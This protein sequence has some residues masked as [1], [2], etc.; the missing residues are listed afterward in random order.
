MFDLRRVVVR[1]LLRVRRCFVMALRVRIGVVPVPVVACRV[2]FIVLSWKVVRIFLRSL[3]LLCR[4]RLRIVLILRLFLLRFPLGMRVLLVHR[5]SIPIEGTACRRTVCRVCLVGKRFGALLRVGVLG[6][7]S[8]S[9]IVR[10]RRVLRVGIRF[11]VRELVRVVRVGILAIKVV[12]ALVDGVPRASSVPVRFSLLLLL[13]VRI[14]VLLPVLFPL[15]LLLLLHLSLCSLVPSI[16]LGRLIALEGRLPVWIRH[17]RVGRGVVDIARIVRRFPLFLTWGS[18]LRGL[19]LVVAV[20][21]VPRLVLRVGVIVVSLSLR[22][23]R[24]LLLVTVVS[25]LP[26]LI[27]SPEFGTR[28]GFILL[29]DRVHV[30]LRLGVILTLL[31]IVERGWILIV[32]AAALSRTR[33]A[34][35]VQACF[36]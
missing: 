10:R 6:L 7:G 16:V 18:S 14:R 30:V 21:L 34:H 1:F 12:R 23:P 24:L 27:A 5:M 8:R 32:S 31:L 11:V 13:L 28:R 9:W 15:S 22:L 17:V 25:L 36:G 33:T 26:L 19:V 35:L 20:V 29:E 3:L 2:R 4:I